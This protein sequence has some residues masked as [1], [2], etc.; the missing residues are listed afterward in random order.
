ME[1]IQKGKEEENVHSIQLHNALYP[2]LTK[3]VEKNPI[4]K[5]K[6][7]KTYVYF[8]YDTAINVKLRM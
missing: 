2:I 4:W 1:K 7:R 5:S 3:E 8:K 6:R